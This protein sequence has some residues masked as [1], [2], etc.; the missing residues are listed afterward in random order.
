MVRLECENELPANAFLKGV[1]NHL[2]NDI[3]IL[4]VEKV[5]EHFHPVFS[6]KEKEYL[7]V[8]TQKDL[9]PFFSQL[10]SYYP[11]NSQQMEVMKSGLE[12]FVGQHDFVNYRCV[13]TN[14]YREDIFGYRKNAGI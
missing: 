14:K 9:G 4:S 12:L 13:G 2:P 7:Y 5:D 10:M 11:L 8:L 1:N 3:K 6:A